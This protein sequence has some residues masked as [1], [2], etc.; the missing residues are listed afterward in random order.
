MSM[1]ARTGTSVAALLGL[2][3]VVPA[4][5]ASAEAS[6]AAPTAQE[7]LT[8]RAPVLAPTEAELA[9]ARRQAALGAAGG[10]TAGQGS[11]LSA[12]STFA[13][14]PRCNST[15]V[16]NFGN[17]GW[18]YWPT[19]GGGENANCFLSYQN[20]YNVAVKPLQN[21]LRFC[22]GYEDILV[23]GYF[24]PRTRDRLKGAQQH[25]GITA[26]GQMGPQTRNRILWWSWRDGFC[27]GVG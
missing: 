7:A 19:Y 26:D 16:R 3:L 24:G 18:A 9:E 23:D 2:L 14:M 27:Y 1:R 20:V 10:L 4:V 15:A 6:T 21:S 12:V 17:A 13:A 11:A 5:S 22:Y 25:E 8:R